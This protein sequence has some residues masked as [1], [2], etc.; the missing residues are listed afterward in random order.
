MKVDLPLALSDTNKKV[1]FRK[2]ILKM[3][4]TSLLLYN[5]SLSYERSLSRKITFVA[6]YRYMPTIRTTTSYLGGRIFE[7]YKEN[8]EQLAN[9]MHSTY[10]GNNTLTG[11]IRFY[12]GKKPGAR[13]FYLSL[14]GRYMDFNIAFPHEH[15]TES[16]I[17]TIPFNGKVTAFAGGLMIGSQWL[18]ARRVTLDWY[19]LGGHYGKLKIDMPGISDLS[20]MTA[21]E[22]RILKEELGVA[23]IGMN[24]EFKVDASVSDNGAQIGG[25]LPFFGLRG[26]GL[27]LGIAF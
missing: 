20:T 24:R 13:G 9:N 7:N 26:F 4:L 14:Y 11:E 5:N 6:G 15:E 1:V 10:L 21:A 3:N 19:I 16:R 22:K 27:N 23:N 17:Y 25:S 8:D 18:I 12:A 2:N